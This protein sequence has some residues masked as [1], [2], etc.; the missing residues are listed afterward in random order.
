M[1][2]QI[3]IIRENIRRSSL[4]RRW[5]LAVLGLF[6]PLCPALAQD[7]ISSP[8]TTPVVPAAVQEVQNNNPMQVFAPPP[9]TSPLVPLQW[10]PVTLHPHLDYQLSYGNGVQA[11]PGQPHNTLVNQVSPGILFNFG[12]HWTLDYTPTLFF[13]SSSSFQNVVNQSVTLGWGSA[14]G[15]DWFFHGSQNYVSTSNPEVQTAAQTDQETYATALNASYQ[16]NE[17]MSLDM[18][19]GQ[20]LSY[21]GNGATPT[22]QLQ[23]LANS[24]SWS[25]MEWLNYQ[26]WPRFSAGLGAGFGYNQQDNSPD[27][28]YEQ[29]QGRVNWRAT[30]KISFQLSG[31][32]QDQQYLSGGASGLLTPIFGGTIQYQPFEQTKLTVNAN[33]TVSNSSY[34]NQVT[35]IT[36]VTADLNQRLLGRLNLDLSGGYSTTEYQASA[37]GLST[38]RNDNVFSFG[39]RL[40]CPLLK[41]ATVSVFYSYSNNASSQSGFATAGSGY[42]YT[43]SQG[44]L[45]IGYRY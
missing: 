2:D 35:I 20:N 22:N 32:L 1:S 5:A 37:V 25:T 14:Y 16:F 41:R 12:D 30:D 33:R 44:G 7:V 45:E 42:G 17:K 36:G 4:F 34:Q 6:L 15:N 13:Y 28:I 3:F 23:N 43:S 26:F 38:S 18:S 8:P 19:L 21:V 10:G 39:A 31:G 40:S 9:D 29:Y 24:K 27:S 11:A